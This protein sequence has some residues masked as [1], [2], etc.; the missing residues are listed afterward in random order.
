MVQ[1]SD[2][3][4]IPLVQGASTLAWRFEGLWV[5][6]LVCFCTT[7]TENNVELRIYDLLLLPFISCAFDLIKQYIAVV[8]LPL[9][10]IVF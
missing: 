9:V 3:E 10:T 1:C 2:P 6:I 4:H 7:K 5:Q 8:F